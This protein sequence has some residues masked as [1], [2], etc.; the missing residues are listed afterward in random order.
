MP[1]QKSLFTKQASWHRD[2]SNRRQASIAVASVNLKQSLQQDEGLTRQIMH[3]NQHLTWHEGAVGELGKRSL[4]LLKRTAWECTAQG[5]PQNLNV[6]V[7]GHRE[8]WRSE[9]ASLHQI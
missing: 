8:T 1:R 7:R 4:D 9:T 6:Q 3:L 5:V 2:G